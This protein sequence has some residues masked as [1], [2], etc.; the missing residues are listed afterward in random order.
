MKREF[1]GCHFSGGTRHQLI[2][3]R[4]KGCICS[5][6]LYAE[7]YKYIRGLCGKINV[8]GFSKID[9]FYLGPWA[10][11]SNS[12][13]TR[14]CC[15]DIARTSASS[16]KSNKKEEI[17]S[18]LQKNRILFGLA[19]LNK[20]F[21]QAAIWFD[22]EPTGQWPHVDQ[23]VFLNWSTDRSF[24]SNLHLWNIETELKL[25]REFK[26]IKVM[27]LWS[28]LLHL[29]VFLYPDGCVSLIHEV[30]IQVSLH[31]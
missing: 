30:V 7:L 26:V 6:K 19:S 24:W 25:F 10:Y 15:T 4:G 5:T 9:S 13:Q 8:L 17:H 31:E 23:L 12:A 22:L 14:K 3:G 27:F 11:E 16:W 1:S 20:C 28:L 21:R 18:S 2:K 29:S